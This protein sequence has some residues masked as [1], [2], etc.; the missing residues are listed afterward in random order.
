[1]VSGFLRLLRKRPVVGGLA[2]VALHLA[3]F[4]ALMLLGSPWVTYTVKRGE[5]LF[6][7]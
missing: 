7:V 2:S 5:P 3:L 4:S 6:T 1:M